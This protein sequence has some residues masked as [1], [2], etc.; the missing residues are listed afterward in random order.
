MQILFSQGCGYGRVKILTWKPESGHRTESDR[1]KIVFV[2]I[3][4]LQLVFLTHTHVSY[5]LVG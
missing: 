3:F 1:L 4:D 5:N 2:E